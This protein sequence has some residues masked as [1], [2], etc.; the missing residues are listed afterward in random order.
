MQKP[1][2]I[3]DRFSWCDRSR[4][5]LIIGQFDLIVFPIRSPAFAGNHWRSHQLKRAQELESKL[6]R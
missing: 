3:G 2:V 1:V 6:T 4:L 5:A